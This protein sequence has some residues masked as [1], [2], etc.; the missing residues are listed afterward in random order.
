MLQRQIWFDT[1]SHHDAA[2][3]CGLVDAMRITLEIIKMYSYFSIAGCGL[4]ETQ[5]SHTI[6]HILQLGDTAALVGRAHG[7]CHN[8]GQRTGAGHARV[9]APITPESIFL[10]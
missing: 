2:M 3:R 5:K 4:S 7:G 8:S 10:C 6:A 1:L 9:H